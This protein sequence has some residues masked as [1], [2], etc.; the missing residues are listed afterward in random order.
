MTVLAVSVADLLQV[1]IVS[2][3]AGLGVTIVF[4]LAI[5]GAI[6]ARDAHREDREAARLAWGGVS[7]AALIGVA[8]AVLAG[9]WVVAS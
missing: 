9:L 8:A 3:V 1:M 5:V 7:V 4:A 2:L 6:H